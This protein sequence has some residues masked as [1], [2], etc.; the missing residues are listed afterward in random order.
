[1]IYFF[2]FHFVVYDM[3]TVCVWVYY[4]FVVFSWCMG[5]WHARVLVGL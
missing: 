4:R 5:W 1:M 2:V 3:T